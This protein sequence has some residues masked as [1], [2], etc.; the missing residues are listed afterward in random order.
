MVVSSHSMNRDGYIRMV[1]PNPDGKQQYFAHRAIYEAIHGKLEEGYVIDH[2]C[3]CRQCC[4]PKHL[5]K[6][7]RKDHLY[8]TNKERYHARKMEARLK[9]ESTGRAIT[10]TK[11]GKEFG[12]SFSIACAWIRGWKS[13]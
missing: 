11:L 4:N 9:W 1:I 13:E 3:K 5:R 8:D 6:V 12:V 10:G 2:L 7:S